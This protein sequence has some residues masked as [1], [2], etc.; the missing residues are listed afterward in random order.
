MKYNY[1]KIDGASKEDI[2]CAYQRLYFNGNVKEIMEYCDKLSAMKFENML[3]EMAKKHEDLLIF[4]R[5]RE[6][7]DWIVEN[8]F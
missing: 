5:N 6:L 2:I 7:H 1:I 4:T 3:L 8:R